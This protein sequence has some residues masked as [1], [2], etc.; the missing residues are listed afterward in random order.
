MSAGVRRKLP[1]RRAAL[2]RSFEHF[3]GVGNRLYVASF[4]FF[5]RDCKEVAEVFVNTSTKAG[6]ESDTNAAD[7]AVAVSLALQ[8]GCPVDVI[9]EAMKRNA[10]GQPT[11]PLA[12]ALDLIAGE[13]ES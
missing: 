6:T 7:C 5:D 11:G 1:N 4:G 3:S 8:Y 10:D 12:H 13:T 2:T 9:R